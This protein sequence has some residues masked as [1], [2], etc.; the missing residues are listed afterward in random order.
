MNE[1]T[2]PSFKVKESI[3]S[4]KKT[5]T[6]RNDQCIF[7]THINNE[8]GWFAIGRVG[9]LTVNQGRLGTKFEVSNFTRYKDTK[10]V[11]MGWF[12]AAKGN[13]KSSAITIR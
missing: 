6:L 5:Y 12:G 13:F 7:V 3:F 8:Q 1:Y 2:R 4:Y 11:K 10:N 9:L